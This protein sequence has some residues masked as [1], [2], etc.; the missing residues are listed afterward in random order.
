METKSIQTHQGPWD[1]S[2]RANE[3]LLFMEK[4][5]AKVDSGDLSTPYRE[6]FASDALFYD[7]DDTIYKGG[8]DVW[9]F[10]KKLFGVAQ[11]IQA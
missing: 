6:W 4:Y 10:M 5:V 11:T 2:T 3:A 9:S 8:E 7:A 1:E